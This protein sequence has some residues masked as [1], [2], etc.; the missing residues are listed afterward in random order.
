MNAF[1][2]TS[3]LLKPWVNPDRRGHGAVVFKP[4]LAPPCVC[5]SFGAS[6]EF[7]LWRYM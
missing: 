3:V 7:I 1:G 2:S 4:D 5:G 6:D